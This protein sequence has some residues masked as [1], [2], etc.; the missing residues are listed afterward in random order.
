MERVAG[1]LCKCD[2]NCANT[3]FGTGPI[4]GVG[5]RSK[6]GGTWC[7]VHAFTEQQVNGLCRRPINNFLSGY[8]IAE[9]G[10]NICLTLFYHY[11][12]NALARTTKLDLTGLQVPQLRKLLARRLNG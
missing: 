2:R 1:M 7:Y 11:V 12:H 10:K 8:V 9:I 5:T 4:R 6:D 3:S